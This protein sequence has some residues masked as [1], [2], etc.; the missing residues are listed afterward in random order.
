LLADQASA[1]NLREEKSTEVAVARLFADQANRLVFERG[2]GEG[3]LYYTAHL[4][5]FLSVADARA[6]NR[7]VIV[8]RTYSIIS[9]DCGNADQPQCPPVTEAKAGEDIRVKVTLVAPNDLYF[10]TLE[11]PI[12]AGA[13]PVD[14]SLLTTSVVGQPPELDPR[15]PFY[16][17]WG[18]WWFSKS[19][20]RDDKVVLF[21]DYLPRGT[22]EY[23]YTLHASRPGTYNVIPTW[24][25]ETYFPEVFGRG[26][27]AVFVIR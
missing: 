22:Y 19:E 5:L 11:D 14:T 23:T 4:N 20:I 21:A 18:W 27:G 25:R 26:D 13:E 24:A 10:V 15:D 6:I 17:G 3:R 12:P 1:A 9:K 7:G 16:Y 8:G 2:A